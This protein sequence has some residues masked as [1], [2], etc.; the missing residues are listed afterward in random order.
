MKVRNRHVAFLAS[1]QTPASIFEQISIIYQL[2]RLF[3]G[4]FTLVLPY[5]PTGTAERVSAFWCLDAVIADLC[6]KSANCLQ[7]ACKS[8]S[9]C[10]QCCLFNRWPQNSGSAAKSLPF[11]CWRVL[12]KPPPVLTQLVGKSHHMPCRTCRC[13]PNLGYRLLLASALACNPGTHDFEALI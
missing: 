1:F 4:S 13:L 5:F 7:I 10:T 2:P 9:S 12:A 8:L 6:M 3:V 11:R